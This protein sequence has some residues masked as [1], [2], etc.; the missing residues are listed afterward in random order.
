MELVCLP[1]H[2]AHMPSHGLEARSV[3]C[4][5]YSIVCTVLYCTVVYCTVLYCTVLV[6]SLCERTWVTF[7]SPAHAKRSSIVG[8]FR[9]L[10]APISLSGGST[11]R[12]QTSGIAPLQHYTYI[13]Q[14]STYVAVRPVVPLLLDFP[15]TLATVV[16]CS[17]VQCSAVQCSA[18][19]CSAVQCSAVQCSTVQYSTVQYSTVQYS[20]I[21]YR[22]RCCF[23]QA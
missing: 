2:T 19:Q 1:L 12:V 4:T 22:G 20:T 16:Q 17:A 6:R 23:H 15:S 7:R 10:R 13:V 14:Y 5:G 3:Y 11:V 8:S 21:Q 18:V 9:A